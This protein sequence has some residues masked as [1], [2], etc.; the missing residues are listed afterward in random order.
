MLCASVGTAVAPLGCDDMKAAK[1]RLLTP[2]NVNRILASDARI[3]QPK[4]KEPIAAPTAFSS[5][6]EEPSITNSSRAELS[7]AWAVLLVW[8]AALAE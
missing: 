7:A 2:I 1:I 6:T 8:R 3:A 5:R 4:A